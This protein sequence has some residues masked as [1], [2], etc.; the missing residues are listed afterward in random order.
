MILLLKYATLSA[1]DVLIPRLLLFRGLSRS[2]FSAIELWFEQWPSLVSFSLKIPAYGT[3][4]VESICKWTGATLRFKLSHFRSFSIF[5]ADAVDPLLSH[6]W[7]VLS[8]RRELLFELPSHRG[9]HSTKERYQTKLRM[10]LIRFTLVDCQKLILI[11]HWW[12]HHVSAQILN[13]PTSVVP[14][15]K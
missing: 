1:P 14:R 15:I 10:L 6:Y 2:E 9:L 5:I 7:F 8:D 12:F 4:H 3:F 13:T 11:P